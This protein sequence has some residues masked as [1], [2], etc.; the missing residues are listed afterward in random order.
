MTT[1]FSVIVLKVQIW[2]SSPV[3]IMVPIALEVS[4]NSRYSENCLN[5]HWTRVPFR[6][7]EILG[8]MRCEALRRKQVGS[9]TSLPYSSPFILHDGRREEF[10]RH[11]IYTSSC[12]RTVTF[13]GCSMKFIFDWVIVNWRQVDSSSHTIYVR[14]QKN[15][16]AMTSMLTKTII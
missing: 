16:L 11:G 14:N 5:R 9:P 8:I 7:V 10:V 4:I 3:T 6:N 13:T 2:S 12:S 15:Y 1:L